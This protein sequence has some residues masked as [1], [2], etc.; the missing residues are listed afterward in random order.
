M[1]FDVMRGFEVGQKIGAPSAVGEFVKQLTERANL[2]LKAQTTASNLNPTNVYTFDSSTGDVT[3]SPGGVNLPPRSRVIPTRTTPEQAYGLSEARAAGSAAG[4]FGTQTTPS[5]Q[6]TPIRQTEAAIR[7]LDEIIQDA[8]TNKYRT[9]PF[10]ARFGGGFLNKRYA[11]VVE[12]PKE[13]GFRKKFQRYQ[14]A[15]AS[16]QSGAARGFKEIEWLAGAQPEPD[17]DTPEQLIQNAMDA[18]RELVENHR[19]MTEFLAKSGFRVP[20]NSPFQAST[21]EPSART[22]LP[23]GFRRR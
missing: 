7:Q 19:N 20:Q 22:G 2:I 10:S 4:S 3:P 18:R 1:A 8:R 9:G 21:D 15:Y 11:A 17:V 5:E 12:S 23:E 13:I 16:A 6:I 14:A